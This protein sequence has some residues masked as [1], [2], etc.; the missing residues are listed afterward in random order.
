MSSVP[1]YSFLP[2]LRTGVANNITQPDHAP[3]VLVRATLPIDLKLSASQIGG[4]TH[5][6]T[7]HKDVSLYGPGD[8]VGI[9][10]RAI[11]KVEPRSRITNFE[12]NYLAYID[13]YD[14]DMPW[15]Y[16]PA[17]ADGASHRLRPWISLVVLKDE[18]FTDG[19]DVRN[20][21]LP[22]FDLAPGVNA[23]DVFPLAAELRAWA[24][25]H[26]N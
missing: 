15:R 17:A 25:V 12:S 24:H 11:V 18:E 19:K 13:F 4:G 14:E 7:V 8:I 21:P 2:W 23:I 5:E 26:V 3:G 16:T 9:D 20:K 6:E 10:L 22:Y 1:T